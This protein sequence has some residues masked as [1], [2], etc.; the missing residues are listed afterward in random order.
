MGSCTVVSPNKQQTSSSNTKFKLDDPFHC[1]AELSFRALREFGKPKYQVSC[2]YL[3][4]LF[5]TSFF[6]RKFVSCL[7]Q[8]GFVGL[9]LQSFQ[10][11]Q[12]HPWDSWQILRHLCTFLPL[13][14][15][16]CAVS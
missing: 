11:K 15:R 6:L 10:M 3:M 14:L 12:T 7:P 4:V 2:C 16:D 5:M 1:Q 9:V 8:T 13:L